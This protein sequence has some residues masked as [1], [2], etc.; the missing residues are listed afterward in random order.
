MGQRAEYLADDLAVD[1]AGSESV[2][3]LMIK[4]LVADACLRALQSASQQGL[5]DLWAAEA[6][7]VASVPASEIDRRRR[8]A[9]SRPLRVDVSHPPT[10][11]RI[12]LIESRPDRLT[13]VPTLA[14]RFDAIDSELKPWADRVQL[15]IRQRH[16]P[17]VRKVAE[18]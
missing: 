4:E 7:F 6:E 12:R 1:V 10:E 15:S 17:T 2:K 11:L 18:K 13:R 16:P 14:Q 3:E 5:S 9:G 8:V